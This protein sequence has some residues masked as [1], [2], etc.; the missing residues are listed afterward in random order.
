MTMSKGIVAL[1][2]TSSRPVAPFVQQETGTTFSMPYITSAP[3]VN[4]SALIGRAPGHVTG[5]PARLSLHVRPLLDGAMLAV[6][7]QHRWT[8]VY[9]LYDSDH[10][11]SHAAPQ[12]IDYL[13]SSVSHHPSSPSF[14]QAAR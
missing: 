1:M 8:T 12:Q 2:S 7:R 11:R 3:S 10:G 13:L 5:A 6:I 9:Y 14:F 4:S